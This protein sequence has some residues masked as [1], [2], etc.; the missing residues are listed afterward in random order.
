MTRKV[1]K[2]IKFVSKFDMNL[3]GSWVSKILQHDYKTKVEIEFVK[4]SF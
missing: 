1:R 3:E 4:K 2:E